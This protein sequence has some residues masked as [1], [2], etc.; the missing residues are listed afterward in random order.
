ML[1]LY[2]KETYR[3]LKNN[4]SIS[5]TAVDEHK[6]KGFSLKGKAK[7]LNREDLSPQLLKAWEE[8]IN[9]RIT[10]RLIKNMKEEKGH[11]KHPE[12]LM[13]EPAYLIE[14][15]VKDIVDL[16]PHHLKEVI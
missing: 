12:A 3:N 16:T 13:P 6:F 8:K 7:I 15:E 11:P 5:I 2:L 9:S 1:D 10:R 14:V 4:P